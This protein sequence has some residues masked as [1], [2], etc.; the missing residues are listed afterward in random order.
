MS[1]RRGG[2]VRGSP[3]NVKGGFP[4]WNG[5]G[6]GDGSGTVLGADEQRDD[7]DD[8]ATDTTEQAECPVW[9]TLV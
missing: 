5:L 7:L 4:T 6:S 3:K 8:A 2:T 1:S 9:I